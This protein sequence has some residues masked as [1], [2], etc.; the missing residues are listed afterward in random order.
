[1]RK[2]IRKSVSLLLLAVLLLGLFPTVAL[3]ATEPTY[4]LSLSVAS[5]TGTINA[6]G[7]LSVNQSNNIDVTLSIASQTASSFGA[8]QATVN[9]DRARFEYV[10]YASELPVKI[11]ADP[12][13]LL[14]TSYEDNE[15]ALT[16]GAAVPIVTFK[17]KARTTGMDVS[18][19]YFSIAEAEKAPVAATAGN[20][21]NLTVTLDETSNSV[22]VEIIRPLVKHTISVQPHISDNAIDIDKYHGQ[23]IPNKTS[24]YNNETITLVTIP[25]EGK[26]LVPDSLYYRI[27]GVGNANYITQEN[28]VYSFIMPDDDVKIDGRFERI[29]DDDEDALKLVNGYYEISTIEDLSWFDEQILAGSASI[30]ALLINDIDLS[31][32]TN[33]K[34]IGYRIED[35]AWPVSYLGIFNG[36]GNKITLNITRD[37]LGTAL[38]ASL[39]DG[40]VIRDLNVEG[41]VVLET[42]AKNVAGIVMNNA[43]TIEN[44]SFDGSVVGKGTNIGGIAGISTS[45]GIIRDCSVSG[46]ILGLF[47]IGGIVGELNPQGTVENCTNFAL[48]EGRN[49]IGGI[50]GL[51]NGSI[52]YCVNNGEINGSHSYVG[53]IAGY[54]TGEAYYCENTRSIT[55]DAYDVG[56]IWGF[57]GRIDTRYSI[58][59]G[60]IT[61][62]YHVGGILGNTSGSY[63][64]GNVN[65]GSITATDD[66]AGGILGYQFS[67]FWEF[68]HNYNGGSV[69]ALSTNDA[70]AGGIAGW[71]EGWAVAAALGAVYGYISNN[72]NTGAVAG[73]SA[74]ATKVGPIVGAY[75]PTSEAAPSSK[76]PGTTGDGRDLFSDNYYAADSVGE[77]VEVEKGDA[78]GA[79]NALGVEELLRNILKGAGIEEDIK[80][81]TGGYPVPES[82]WDGLGEE[83]DYGETDDI[84]VRIAFNVTPTDATVVVLDGEGNT[85]EPVG[86][87]VYSLIVGS[88]YRY[89]VSADD[90]TSKSDSIIVSGAKTVTVALRLTDPEA[91]YKPGYD[92][93]RPSFGIY[94][95]N[96]DL[97]SGTQIGN[98]DYDKYE[99]TYL[100]KNGYRSELITDYSKNPLVYSGIDNYPATRLGVVLEGITA[101]DVIAYYNANRKTSEVEYPALD[102]NSYTTFLI[103]C[104]TNSDSGGDPFTS[105]DPTKPGSWAWN[106]ALDTLAGTTR[107]YYPNFLIGGNHGDGVRGNTLGAGT[108]VPAVIAVKSYN[109][110]IMALNFFEAGIEMDK[111]FV[112]IINREAQLESA[113]KYLVG[114]ADT[115]RALRNFEGMLPDIG[116]STAKPLGADSSYYIGSVWITPP[117]HDIKTQVAKN[118]SARIT[119]TGVVDAFRAIEGEEVTFRVSSTSEVKVTVG[120]ELLTPI[121]GEYSFTMQ[122]ADATI[123]IEADENHNITSTVTNG[124]ATVTTT[125][126][127]AIVGVEVSFT[128]EPEIAGQLIDSVSVNDGTVALTKNGETYTFTMPNAEAKIAVV[129]KLFLN[130]NTAMQ[131]GTAKLTFTGNTYHQLNLAYA[132]ETV[133]FTAEPVDAGMSI[134]SVS[135]NGGDPLT[136]DET[137]DEYSFVMPSTDVT[138][139]IVLKRAEDNNDIIIEKLETHT[140]EDGGTVVTATVGGSEIIAGDSVDGSGP[141]VTVNATADA[142]NVTD[143][144]VTISQE[145]IEA[146]KN[147]IDDP[148][149]IIESVELVTNIG[150]MTLPASVLAELAESGEPATI[151]IAAP[152][153]RQIEVTIT[154][155]DEPVDA[156]VEVEVQYE[157]R[158]QA[159][160]KVE[161]ASGGTAQS[162]ADSGAVGESIVVDFNAESGVTYTITEP[163]AVIVPPEIVGNT[164]TST[165]SGADA[166]VGETVIIA[167]TGTGTTKNANIESAKLTIDEPALAA[168]VAVDGNLTLITDIGEI[169]FDAATLADMAVSADA[170]S[171]VT[172]TLQQTSDS[173]FELTVTTGDEPDAP[174]AIPP[175]NVGKVTVSLPYKQKNS[176]LIIKVKLTVNGGE[177][178]EVDASYD[179]ETETVTFDIENF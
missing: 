67:E 106:G 119:L 93:A 89:T 129:L 124:K 117:Y 52:Y 76:S 111:Y 65:Y 176:F 42:T 123:E 126:K 68:E 157:R 51:G 79:S 54:G 113:V 21:D 175:G 39:G 92:K 109:S 43:G 60:D 143:V 144:K 140:G 172:V 63:V 128:V 5:T 59:R 32:I 35:A 99:E 167:L 71:Y 75:V 24:A 177:P 25:N 30:N 152:A 4:A 102:K 78:V 164:A 101:D 178:I 135:V 56:G 33:F 161:A 136:A 105:N 146:I 55:T 40:G 116:T 156:V 31:G 77:S 163:I 149:N 90:Y 107:Y 96:R 131:E 48:V 18:V 73:G 91:E 86:D 64:I 97:K 6:D 151:E 127:R 34:S 153:E 125:L 108:P 150:T 98:W 2:N 141:A 9:Y 16:G 133:K 28:D 134:K 37:T 168:L 154:S 173:T 69:K 94:I 10:S 169:K 122:N 36:N 50:A 138:I 47:N 84:Y 170:D 103:N 115:E 66:Y 27:N 179:A 158:S 112:P 162:A 83:T 120:G 70:Y 74:E 58:N 14:I 88:V 3:A 142:N 95:L 165:I 1:M 145:A 19:A 22:G 61:G 110:R 81:N 29:P 17:F 62:S 139:T 11:T 171:P 8:V 26:R 147:A 46:T 114:L 13:A 82:L 100:D 121:N 87:K 38:F 23:I 12:G 174:S 53:G 15:V 7:L 166:K 80:Y 148:Q 155:G 159:P 49:S 104:A 44:C 130:I 137:S 45:T 118:V 160:V 132:G 85:V 20:K 72:Y 57:G 41:S